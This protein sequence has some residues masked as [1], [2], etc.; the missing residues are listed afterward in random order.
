MHGRTVVRHADGRVALAA[1]RMDQRTRNALGPVANSVTVAAASSWGLVGVAL[2]KVQRAAN[3]DDMPR[4][5][6]RRARMIRWC[7]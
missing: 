2:R 3:L 6:R 5:S 1:W 7:T 4:A